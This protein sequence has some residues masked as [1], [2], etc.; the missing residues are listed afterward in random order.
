M[1]SKW[2]IERRGK[3][4]F[5]V[6]F[7]NVRSGWEGWVLLRSDVHHDNPKS[8]RKLEKKHLDEAKERNA[9]IVDNGDLFCAMQGAYDP[10]KSK[11]S[12][13]PEH[14]VNDYLDALV[15]TAAEFY[16]PYAKQFGVLGK[17]NHETNISR[18]QETDLTSR[19]VQILKLQ[20][21]PVQE[22]GYSGW[23][24]FRFLKQSREDLRSR[25]SP[26]LLHH[27]HGSGGGGPVTQGVIDT[28]RISVYTPDAD[29][30][31][32]GHHHTE[33]TVTMPRQRINDQMNVYRDEQVHVRVPGYK[34][35]W[36]DGSG[37][38]EVER[39]HGPKTGGAAWVHF[40][41]LNGKVSFEIRK[42]K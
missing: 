19:L 9:I 26:I 16:K 3:N 14:N 29:I 6:T 13:R 17:G 1:S 33:W 18:R 15:T 41:Y 42:A 21:S 22:S 38:F 11:S 31:L 35:A 23:I 28:N 4:T 37:G 39:R 8:D 12:I 30:I 34:D 2:T 10:R 25:C 5:E 24:K 32:T 40:T 27:Y 20:G 36:G 7:P